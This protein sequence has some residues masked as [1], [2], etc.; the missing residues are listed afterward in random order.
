MP[1]PY[2]APYPAHSSEVLPSVDPPSACSSLGY[3]PYHSPYS[4]CLLGE[5]SHSTLVPSVA[6]SH[7]AIVEDPLDPLPAADL[8][9]VV[10]DS[11]SHSWGDPVL[12]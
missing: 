11:S 9:G 12:N 3:S 1:A 10:G 5:G 2:P 7:S 6:S 8:V 4:A